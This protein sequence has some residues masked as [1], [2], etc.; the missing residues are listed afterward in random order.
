MGCVSESQP[1]TF[2]RYTREDTNVGVEAFVQQSFHHVITHA[3]KPEAL[4][5]ID[6]EARSVLH[7]VVSFDVSAD[8]SRFVIPSITPGE[9][10][11]LVVLQNWEAQAAKLN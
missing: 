6:A 7:S 8:G 2:Y 4:F 1:A 5:T 3:G 11:A 10:S 9:S